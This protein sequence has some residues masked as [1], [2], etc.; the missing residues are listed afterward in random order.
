MN[1]SLKIS[2]CVLALAAVGCTKPFDTESFDFDKVIVVDGQITDEDKFHEI[3]LSYTYPIGED[4]ESPLTGATVWVE[5]GAGQ[6]IDY[7]ELE[8][9]KYLSTI[10]FAGQ[11]GQAYRLFFTTPAGG[12][13]ASTSSELIPSPP[14]DSIYAEYAVVSTDE[15]TFALDGAQFFID[16]H[17]E[18]QEAKYF[19]Y[20]WV[21]DY[22]ISVPFPSFYE[23][24][25]DLGTQWDSTAMRLPDDFVHICY[26]SGTSASIIIGTSVGTSENRVVEQPVNFVSTETD[27]LRTRYAL[28][29]MQYAVNES[30]YGFYRKLKESNESTG[31]LFDKQQ[32]TITG[33]I[34]SLDNPTETILGFFEVAGVSS[35]RRFF[36]PT[37]IDVRIAPQFRYRCPSSSI[38]D[39]SRDSLLYYLASSPSL[40]IVTAYTPTA[41]DEFRYQIASQT[42]SDCSWYATTTPPEYWEN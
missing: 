33:N 22:K 41:S 37:D 8:P 25:F 34:L 9:G 14:I 35:K 16:S 26:Q 24:F 21:E 15:S 20:E 29:V 2:I 23:Y 28:Q 31:S 42:C 30:A 7:E 18:T 32:G 4:Q 13:Y 17:D 3:L 1:L 5:N 39:S 40:R 19:R 12:K 38:V 10:S 27:R 6:R 11:A 36:S